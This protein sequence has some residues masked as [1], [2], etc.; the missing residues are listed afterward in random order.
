MKDKDLSDSRSKIKSFLIPTILWL[1]GITPITEIFKYNSRLSKC[2]EIISSKKAKGDNFKKQISKTRRAVFLTLAP[3]IFALS[4]HVNEVLKIKWR[5]TLPGFFKEISH[6]NQKDFIDLVLHNPSI[7]ISFT[8]V[9]LAYI[10]MQ[11]YFWRLVANYEIRT[12]TKELAELALRLNLIEENSVKNCLWTKVGVLM[13]LKSS[14]A[15][16]L[17]KNT[18]FWNQLDMEP[19]EIFY[20]KKGKKNFFIL[21]GFEF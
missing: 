2:S 3:F 7:S 8:T 1:S 14:T 10:I 11:F 17:V 19:G 20:S 13:E 9:I 18:T 5:P 4:Y 16:D 15:T 21:S 12:K 6:L